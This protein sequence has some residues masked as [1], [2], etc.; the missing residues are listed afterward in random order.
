M[1]WNDMLLRRVGCKMK[2]GRE[3]KMMDVEMREV[4][5][6]QFAFYPDTCII[7]QFKASSYLSHVTD[8]GQSESKTP[9]DVGARGYLHLQ[10][11]LL[12]IFRT[13]TVIVQALQDLTICTQLGPH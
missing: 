8:W 6:K 5:S 13:S 4:D 2:V 3:I 12:S 1:A 9:S 7:L 11:H 10:N